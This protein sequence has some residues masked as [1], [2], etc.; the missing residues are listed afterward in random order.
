MTMQFLSRDGPSAKRVVLCVPRLWTNCVLHR[1]VLW[2]G[3]LSTHPVD[4]LQFLPGHRNHHHFSDDVGCHELQLICHC[5]VCH[6]K[7]WRRGRCLRVSPWLSVLPPSSFTIE[8]FSSFELLIL[9]STLLMFRTYRSQRLLRFRQL[10]AL[11]FK[12][13]FWCNGKCWS[14]SKRLLV[15]IGTQTRNPTFGVL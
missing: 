4:F 5:E 7:S 13:L 11:H 15:P 2:V 1:C 14:L 6:C 8:V 12:A 9:L 10:S 3:V